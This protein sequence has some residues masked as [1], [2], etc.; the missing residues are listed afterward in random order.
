MDPQPAPELR[1]RHLD[2]LETGL[3][4]G[5]L[6]LE[7]LTRVDRAGLVRGP[8]PELGAARTRGPVGVGLGGRHLL[9]ASLDPH[10]SLQRIP[11]HEQSGPRRGPK[12]LAL[13]GVEIRE[14]H[15]AVR[16][17][18]L[19]QHGPGARTRRP[20]GTERDGGEHHGGRIRDV[21]ARLAPGEGVPQPG[22]A[23]L[24]RVR[25]GGVREGSGEV[26]ES[27]AGETVRSAGHGADPMP[28]HGA[29]RGHR[30]TSPRMR[31]PHPGS[32]RCAR[33]GVR[34]GSSEVVRGKDRRRRTRRGG[35]GVRTGRD[36][37]P[38][39]GRGPG[40]VSAPRGSREHGSS[41]A[42]EHIWDRC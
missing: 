27:F 33:P 14:D 24:E 16:V 8:G 35:R 9:D 36:A 15:G 34:T 41:R 32:A 21:A 29:V 12:L 38:V 40:W 23:Q 39:R 13:V 26:V 28:R 2:P 5:V 17:E 10:L 1:A 19:Q 6:R 25:G 18:A 31:C 30:R 22:V 3:D 7:L 37:G 42:L 20:V 4:L 11:R